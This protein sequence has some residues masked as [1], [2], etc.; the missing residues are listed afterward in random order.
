VFLPSFSPHC[1]SLCILCLSLSSS[2]LS[3]TSLSPSSFPLISSM[4]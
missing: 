4:K 2:A 3:P 1:P